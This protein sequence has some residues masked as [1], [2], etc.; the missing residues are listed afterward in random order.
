MID[1][2]IELLPDVPISARDHDLFARAPVAERLVELACA[3][4]LAAPRAV[5]L[6]GGSGSGKTSLLRLAG[7]LLAERGGVATVAL[8]G[9]AY[10]GAQT[11]L[12]ALLQELTRFFEAAGVVDTTDRIR[13]TL[14]GYGGL[15]SSIARIAGVKV[16]VEGA[17]KRSPEDLREEIAEMTH[18]VGTRI[19]VV[20]DH[21]D[22]LPTGEL[23]SVLAALPYY[24]AIPYVTIVLAI[25]RRAT[26]TRL[27]RVD[28]DPHVL[29]RLVQVEV[30]VPPV[31]RTL[32]ARA[33][34]G[35]VARLAERLHRDLDAVLP[36]FDPAGGPHGGLAL[37]LIET[38]RDAKRVA[39]A[40]AAAVPLLPADADLRDAVL[41]LVLRLL[42]PELD[43][44]RLDARARVAD[45][46]AREEL[47]AELV[48]RITTH[49]RGRAARAALDALL[50]RT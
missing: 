35:G 4:P 45:P 44:S 11:L 27:P 37:D 10:P 32:L 23:A 8:D 2:G 28:G 12:A 19:V 14:A 5:A 31:D 25:D 22:R 16:D 36:L 49:R 6:T 39:N 9:S 40:I 48:G 50:T 17:L 30:A 42:V 33:V 3:Q 1:P 38:P 18:E 20:I 34:A 21:L 41:D 24:A 43:S 26:A 13:D 7:H 47:R 46:R 29:E 15:V